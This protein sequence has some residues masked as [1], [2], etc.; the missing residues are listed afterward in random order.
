MGLGEAPE[1]TAPG[2]RL[3]NKGLWARVR[4]VPTSLEGLRS[5]VGSVPAG[6]RLPPG[7]SLL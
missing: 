5:H 1:E 4:H 6:G 3:R 7:P 2:T